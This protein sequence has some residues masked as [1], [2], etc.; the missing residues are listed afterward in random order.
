MLINCAGIGSQIFRPIAS[1]MV[2]QNI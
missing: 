2:D 1:C